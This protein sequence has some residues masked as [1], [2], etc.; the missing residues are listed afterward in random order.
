MGLNSRISS[1][2]H[3][4]LGLLQRTQHSAVPVMFYVAPTS[5]YLLGGFSIPLYTVSCSIGPTERVAMDTALREAGLMDPI[6][7]FSATLHGSDPHIPIA[8]ETESRIHGYCEFMFT[9]ILS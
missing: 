2:T 9:G 7:P 6:E 4:P 5:K 1:Q 3:R 8:S